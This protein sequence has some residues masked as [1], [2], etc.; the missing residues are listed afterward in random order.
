MKYCQTI[1]ESF[2]VIDGTDF[3]TDVHNRY[4][5]LEDEAADDTENDETTSQVD[6]E[7]IITN[8]LEE[9]AQLDEREN[10]MIAERDG[11]R[12]A[13]EKQAKEML[14]ASEKRFVK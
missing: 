3:V 11:A 10:Q 6:E 1:Q 9:V 12:K 5:Y 2:V 8:Q 13:Q 4:V 14:A 7:I